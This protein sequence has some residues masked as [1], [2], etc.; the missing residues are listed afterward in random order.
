[1]RSEKSLL[2][3]SSSL[4]D[5]SWLRSENYVAKI[6][7]ILRWDILFG[8]VTL[9]K[10]ADIDKYKYFGYENEITTFVW[11]KNLEIET[12]FQRLTGHYWKHF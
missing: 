5:K 8:A 1:M 9:T 12:L 10:N 6:K 11:L 2:I 4:A 3:L 7:Q